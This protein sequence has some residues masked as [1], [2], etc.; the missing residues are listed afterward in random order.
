MEGFFTDTACGL[1]ECLDW[2][3]KILIRYIMLSR[4]RD[5]NI[6]ANLPRKIFPCDN[7]ANSELSERNPSSNWFQLKNL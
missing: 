3:H 5:I 1:W 6:L 2:K 7:L 4:K